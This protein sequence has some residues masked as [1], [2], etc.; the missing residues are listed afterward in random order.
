M[1]SEVS[2]CIRKLHRD[3]FF[4]GMSTTTKSG[5][6]AFQGLVTQMPAAALVEPGDL[7]IILLKFSPF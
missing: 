6:G 7:L 2:G 1:K 5:N 4:C 3:F